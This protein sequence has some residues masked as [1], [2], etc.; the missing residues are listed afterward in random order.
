VPARS[1]AGALLAAVGIALAA[2]VPATAGPPIP[3]GVDQA[4]DDVWGLRAA[5]DSYLVVHTAR[6]RPFT[7]DT[8]VLTGSAARAWWLDPRTGR[9]IDAGSVPRGSAVPFHPP[10]TGPED[11]D[12]AWTLVVAD[13]ARPAGVGGRG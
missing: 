11:A 2:P 1:V 13:A 12:L 5:D 8:T 3:P 4:V 6:G 10:R 7:L 9:A